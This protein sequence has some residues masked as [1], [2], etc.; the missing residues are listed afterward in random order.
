MKRFT[1]ISKIN[2]IDWFT[3]LFL[4]GLNKIN[5]IK[6]YSKSNRTYQWLQMAATLLQMIKQN[7][8]LFLEENC[9]EK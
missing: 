2:E 8:F 5:C 7:N 3:H 4:K 9:V 1:G 6:I